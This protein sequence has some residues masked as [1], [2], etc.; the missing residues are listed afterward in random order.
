LYPGDTKNKNGKLRLL[1]EAAPMAHIMETA[2][3]LATTGTQRILEVEPKDI[4]QRCSVC[5]GSKV[6]VQE[7]IDLW[8]EC[9]PK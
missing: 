6:Q 4:H 1:Y 5:I 9:G 8:K 2:G 3:G 7:I